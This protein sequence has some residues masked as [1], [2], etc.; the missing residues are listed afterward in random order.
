MG[1]F[2]SG[3]VR[4]WARDA[5]PKADKCLATDKQK[6]SARKLRLQDLTSAF[7]IWGIGIGLAVLGFCLEH[8]HLKLNRLEKQR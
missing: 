1:L 6:T 2:E 5:V 7:L 4:F 3:L 8:L